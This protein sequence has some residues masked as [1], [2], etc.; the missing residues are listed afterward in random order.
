[1]SALAQYEIK[2]LESV[3]D[4]RALLTLQVQAWTY[5]CPKMT[6]N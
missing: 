2:A 6:T 1:M 3:V 5:T 4:C